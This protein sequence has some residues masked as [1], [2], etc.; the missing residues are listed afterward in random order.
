MVRKNGS[1]TRRAAALAAV[2]TVSA[3]ALNACAGLAPTKE[4]IEVEDRDSKFAQAMRMASQV[5]AGGDVSAAALFY[6]RANVLKP[7]EASALLGLADTSMAIGAYDEA[8]GYYRAA[9]AID[10]ETPGVHLNYG[11]LLLKLGL[12]GD[13]SEALQLAVAR[14]PEDHRAHNGLGI[15]YDLLGLHADAQAAYAT[16]LKHTPENASLR[17]NHALSLAITGQRSA[18]IKELSEL[19]THPSGGT[20]ARQNLALVYALDGRMQEAMSLAARDLSEA[21]VQSNLAAYQAMRALPPKE[22]AA[23]VFGIKPLGGAAPA[24]AGLAALTD[25]GGADWRREAPASAPVA[26]APSAGFV[27]V[28]MEEVETVMADSR[29]AQ[30][31][32][33]YA[34]RQYSYRHTAGP[35]TPPEASTAVVAAEMTADAMSAAL[36]TAINVSR[37]PAATKRAAGTGDGI[38]ANPDVTFG[39]DFHD[40]DDAED[41]AETMTASDT[42][43]VAAG[44]QTVPTPL[45]PTPLGSI[46]TAFVEPSK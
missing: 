44:A 7:D 25:G 24:S 10:P 20:R 23:V 37:A 18:A 9:I 39:A 40:D 38:G 5:R 30:P 14:D 19:V 2:L 12:P 17:N 4:E 46:G 29:A 22:L 26:P 34:G 31:A 27:V 42:P 15:A 28:D 21:Q 45:A 6:R 43:S 33:A 11:L 1:S 36:T 16:G 8:A 35:D 41:G 13:A 32:A 3:L